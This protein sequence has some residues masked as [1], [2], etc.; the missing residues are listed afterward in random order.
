M[1]VTKEIL[2]SLS[3]EDL[4]KVIGNMHDIIQEWNSGYGLDKS[5]GDILIEIGS[6]CSSYCRET[7][8]WTMPNL[9]QII[10]DGKINNIIE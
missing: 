1:P 2:D 5:D 8:D 9:T 10:R 4:I 3:K 7:T 6:A